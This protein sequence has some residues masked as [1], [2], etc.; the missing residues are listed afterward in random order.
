[1]GKVF[2]GGRRRWLSMLGGV[3]AVV[4]LTRAERAS[5]G[6]PAAAAPATTDERLRQQVARQEIRELRLAYGIATDLI[7]AKRESGR[8]EG[9]D[10]YHRIF[11]PQARIGADGIDAVTGPDA[12]VDVVAGALQPFNATQHLIGTQ[13][14]TDLRLPDARGAGGSARMQSYLQAWHS[15]AD[16][17]LWLFMGT[18]EDELTYSEAHGWQ[19]AAMMLRQVAADHRRLGTPSA[20]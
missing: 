6:A 5:A 2:C 14:V 8:S 10:I 18:Y 20:A 12:W 11:T 9:R 17:E 15:T 19:I 16:G 7:G 3:V 4:G 13:Y 1:M